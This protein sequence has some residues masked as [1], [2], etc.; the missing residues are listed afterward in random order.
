MRTLAYVLLALCAWCAGAESAPRDLGRVV[1]IGDSLTHGVGSASYRWPLHKI[2]VDNGVRFEVVG[3]AEG[4]RYA[5]QGIAPG[6]LYRGVP[7]NNR[8][9]SITS[10]CAYEISGRKHTSQRLG[11]TDI[12]T[13][14]GQNAAYTGP[15]KLPAGPP[16]DTAFILIGTNDILGD[17]AGRFH[18]PEHMATLQRDLLHPES[19]DMSAIVAA[20]RRANPRV[21]IIVLSIPTWAYH[22]RNDTAA[23]Y[24]AVQRYNRALAA[25]AAEKGA[26][27]VDVYHVLADAACVS[28]PGRGVPAFFYAEPRMRLHPSPQGDLL[29]A[30]EVARAMGYRGRTADLPALPPAAAPQQLR[31]A[32]GAALSLPLP[33]PARVDFSLLVP[34]VGNGPAGG[35]EQ[36][37]G[38]RLRFGDG[39]VGGSLTI[40]ESYI[41]WA[42]GSILY[43]ADM[44]AA[45]TH[46]RIAWHPG[47]PAQGIARGF[48]VWLRGQL[49]GEALPPA[50]T[51]PTGLHLHNELHSL[52]ITLTL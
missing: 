36:G 26:L 50:P 6:T 46:L 34:A 2:L 38:L 32:P 10:E 3:V 33:A 35:W 45:P 27:F 49:I 19:G 7:F 30:G 15:Y 41:L 29:I 31:L 1:F 43:S 5:E 22:A 51:P 23:A 39:A 48:Y 25:W 44:S 40:S 8:H 14:L 47:D 42:D 21:R 18:T 17:Y 9:C 52:P 20:L 4:N 28:T 16:P 37:R 24:A 13:W 11:G 12:H